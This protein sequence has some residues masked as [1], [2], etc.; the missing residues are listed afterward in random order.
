MSEQF[1]ATSGVPA[2]LFTPSLVPP[3]A[4]IPLA[5]IMREQEADRA[6]E[7]AQPKP[8]PAENERNGKQSKQ[9]KQSPQSQ[10]AGKQA[11]KQKP[12]KTRKDKAA[13]TFDPASFAPKILAKRAG[14]SEPSA[15]GQPIQP[16]SS[17]APSTSSNSSERS[18]NE[19][20]KGERA[21][22]AGE[23][24]LFVPSPAFSTAAKREQLTAPKASHRRSDPS[25][26]HTSR[27]T[28]ART[29]S[30]AIA[31][32]SAPSL[33]AATQPIRIL[34]ASMRLTHQDQLQALL[35]DSREF[36]VVA[37]IGMQRCGKSHVLNELIRRQGGW[38][39]FVE[40]ETAAHL[41]GSS[42][43]AGQSAMVAGRTAVGGADSG[44]T[45]TGVDV[46]AT[47]ERLFYIDTQPLLSPSVAEALQRDER[48]AVSHSAAVHNAQVAA[49]M[50]DV[51]LP[52]LLLC[53]AHTLLVTVS[54]PIPPSFV[55]H[56]QTV[57]QLFSSLS[58][59]LLPRFSH[60]CHVVLLI[61]RA[62][63]TSADSPYSL[64][65][66]ALQQQ[67]DALFASSLAAFSPSGQVEVCLLPAKERGSLYDSSVRVLAA[68]LWAL[69]GRSKSQTGREREREWGRRVGNVY[70]A[71]VHSSAMRDQRKEVEA[72]LA[73]ARPAQQGASAAA[74]VFNQPHSASQAQRSHSHS[75]PHSGGQHRGRAS[76]GREGGGSSSMTVPPS[77]Y[78]RDSPGLSH[79][80]LYQPP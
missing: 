13:R 78:Q 14:N 61:N 60:S 58:S 53:L 63:E 37:A 56:M 68:K 23:R 34:T 29:N 39:G 67:V 21:P 19:A 46:I 65:P 20:A 55:A 22:A 27:A 69:T 1:A 15:D 76:T 79:Q 25:R 12:Q 62:Q 80:K 30:P 32:T 7:V 49:D 24:T 44:H 74:S 5:D 17:P 4:V 42:S 11:K 50:Y 75:S 47:P 18:A 73:S 70:N 38:K 8:K 57:F 41:P 71:L 36:Y 2:A 9:P 59:T 40:A 31:S 28:A 51:Q 10:Q 35:S 66:H 52:L 77:L 43:S 54:W 72:R 33:S 64:S 3:A 6:S 45:T 16:A 48:D 26:P